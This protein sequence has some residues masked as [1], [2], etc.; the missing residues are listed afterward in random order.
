[1]LLTVILLAAGG[2]AYTAGAI[3]K[4]DGYELYALTIRYG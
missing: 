2:V 3:A 4:A 1:V